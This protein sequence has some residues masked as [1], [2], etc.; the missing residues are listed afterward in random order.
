[1][2]LK[3][4]IYWISN[5]INNIPQGDKDNNESASYLDLDII[6]NKLKFKDMIRE[7]VLI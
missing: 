4:L 5:E 7:I 3:S 1:M 2:I 6:D